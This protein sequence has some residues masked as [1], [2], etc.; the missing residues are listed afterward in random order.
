MQR[1]GDSTIRRLTRSLGALRLTLA[2]T[3][4]AV[5]ASMVL[6][7]IILKLA[8]FTDLRVG[9][10]IS[11]L[12]PATL[13]PAGSYLFFRLLERLEQAEA[14]QSALVRKLQQALD[15]VRA[16]SGLLPICAACKSVRDD[17]G[18]WHSVEHYLSQHSEAELTHGICPPCMVELYP[19]VEQQTPGASPR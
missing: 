19:E 4:T 6:T 10:F 16:L 14:S 12:M 11:F 9:L 13:A 2:F 18:Y 1:E 5:L 8:G 17:E 3:A 15:E 7:V